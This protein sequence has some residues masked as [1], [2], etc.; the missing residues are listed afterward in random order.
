MTAKKEH[1]GLTLGILFNPFFY[2]G[3]DSWKTMFCHNVSHILLRFPQHVLH[4]MGCG[5]DQPQA[6]SI[7]KLMC[8]F[9]IL[10]LVLGNTRIPNTNLVQ[11][12]DMRIG[13]AVLGVWWDWRRTDAGVGIGIGIGAG[14]TFRRVFGKD[15]S[16]VVFDYSAIII[17]R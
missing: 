12:F 9:T 1:E 16:V 15:Q 14:W 10:I 7:H 4:F 3:A 17:H 6:S 13:K 2:H 8:W 11:V 5:G